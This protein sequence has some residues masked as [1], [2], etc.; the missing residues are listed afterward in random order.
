MITII[1][2][3][4][5]VIWRQTFDI[6]R[7]ALYNLMELLRWRL[8]ST[9][10]NE[11]QIKKNLRSTRFLHAFNNYTRKNAKNGKQPPSAVIDTFEKWV[12]VKLN[13][14]FSSFDKRNLRKRCK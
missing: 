5:N 8:E 11:M 6:L 1:N 3:W 13:P 14:K 7:S 12:N 4:S 9:E 10:E 2:I